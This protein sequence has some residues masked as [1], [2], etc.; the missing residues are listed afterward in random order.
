MSKNHKA[1]TSHSGEIQTHSSETT[2]RCSDIQ[3]R[4]SGERQQLGLSNLSQLVA[5][6]T[7]FAT[8]NV[9]YFSQIEHQIKSHFTDHISSF[10]ASVRTPLAAAS[11]L[12]V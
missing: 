6:E 12:N 7:T 1:I 2:S 3:A 9:P 4:C 8:T 11:T 10:L 5:A